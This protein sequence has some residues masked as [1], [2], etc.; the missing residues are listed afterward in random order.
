MATLGLTLFVVGYGIG[1]LFLAPLSEIAS[2]GRSPPYIFTLFL[3]VVLQ[4]ITATVQNVPGLMVL[5]FL[6]GFVGSPVL[7]TGGASIGDMFSV[8]ARPYAVGI[9][10]L[11][12][13]QGPVLG[14]LVGGFAIE[15]EDWRWA[16]WILLWLDG[17]CLA[18]LI[19]FLPETSSQNILLRRAQ[20]LRA[21]TGNANLRSEGEIQAA[22][23]TKKDHIRN[24]LW[25]PL[26]LSVSEPIVFA[27]NL[28]I[29]LIYACEH[30]ASRSAGLLTFPRHFVRLDRKLRSCVSASVRL[31]ARPERSGVLGPCRW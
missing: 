7:A 25:M 21:R 4:P 29:G 26:Y 22:K 13:V 24:T 15:A 19:F 6:A 16:F 5:R 23:L 3:F 9:W 17:F 31:Y 12:A 14:P 8:K 18:V 11:A 20:R 28:Y 27:L 10:G 1:P 2:I 30:F